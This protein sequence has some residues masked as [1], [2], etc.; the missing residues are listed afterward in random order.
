MGLKVKLGPIAEWGLNLNKKHVEVNHETFGTTSEGIYAIG[1]V[2][3]YPG[4][5][6]LILTGFY[7]GA[8]MARAAF[9]YAFPERKM[10]G[11]YTTTNSVIQERLGVAE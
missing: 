11:G 10:A 1:D 8:V 4:K 7:E 3:T 2:C 6:K 9:K 5:I